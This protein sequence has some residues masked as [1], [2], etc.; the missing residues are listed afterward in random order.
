MNKPIVYALDLTSPK[1][2]IKAFEISKRFEGPLYVAYVTDIEEEREDDIV[3]LGKSVTESYINEENKELHATMEA[4]FQKTGVQPDDVYIL[5]GPIGITVGK[6]SKHV[7]A[8]LI[9]V[10]KTHHHYLKFLGNQRDIE[11]H[12]ETDVYVINS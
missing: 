10:S 12:S 7:N 11:K 2:L 1:D 5:N 6:F 4:L 8:Q 3:Y 9:V